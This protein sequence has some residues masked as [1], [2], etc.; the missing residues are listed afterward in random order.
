MKEQKAHSMNVHKWE[1]WLA[2]L[3]PVVGSEQGLLR[4]AIIVS[5]DRSNRLLPVVNA[6]PVTSRKNQRYIY[7]NEVLIPAGRFGLPKESVALC[8]QIRTLDKQRLLKFY[9]SLTDV[10]LQ[11]S[12][13]FALKFQMGL[14]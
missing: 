14:P 10:G 13:Y 5:E 12:I 3:E 1:I 11:Q 4:P 9:G 6:I 8:Y 2:D 7:A